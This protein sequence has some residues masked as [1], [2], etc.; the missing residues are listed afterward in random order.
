[1]DP[2][3]TVAGLDA[4]PLCDPG[5]STPAMD[6]AIA[7]WLGG[8]TREGIPGDPWADHAAR[9]AAQASRQATAD[10]QQATARAA[11]LAEAVARLDQLAAE[12]RVTGASLRAR[13]RPEDFRPR[14]GMPPWPRGSA[15]EAA[16]RRRN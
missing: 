3:V 15:G 6:K 1:M 9:L 16:N 14:R 7:G 5:T 2:A 8:M 10:A 4:H 11:Q 12:T 13:M